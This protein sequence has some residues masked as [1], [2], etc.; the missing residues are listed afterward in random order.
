MKLVVAVIKPFKLD[1]CLRAL[2]DAGVTDVIH[3]EAR[4][5]GRQKTHLQ[6]YHDDR[7]A[8]AFLP[9]VR[10]EFSVAPEQVKRAIEAVLGACR[11]GRQGDGKIW[12]LDAR[13][14]QAQA[15]GA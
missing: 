11:T 5:Y 1:A 4:G 13:V 6:D 10:V 2:A 15:V 14:A 7:F 3:S 8:V 12:V 9:K